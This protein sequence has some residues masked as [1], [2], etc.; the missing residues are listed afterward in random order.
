VGFASIA[1]SYRVNW[2]GNASSLTF[3]FQSAGDTTLIINAPDG[4]WWCD[5]DSAGKPNPRVVIAS[6]RNGQYTVW[7]GSFAVGGNIS[8][9]LS[10][11]DA[12]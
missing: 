12:P 8:G 5:D 10:V 1:P 2:S 3:N 4:S 11:T 7:V 9:T 6:P